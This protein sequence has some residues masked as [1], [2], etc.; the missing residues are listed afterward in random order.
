MSLDPGL[1]P[2]SDSVNE[3]IPEQA[4]L[5]VRGEPQDT[6]LIIDV[7]HISYAELGA[8]VDG[9]AEELGAT[10]R[11]VFLEV[12]NDV[13]SVVTYLACLQA[14]HPVLLAAPGDAAKHPDL[15][16]RYRP[17]VVQAK[18]GAW[19]ELFPGSR[20][21][22]HPDL[23]VL[24]ST[25]GSTG[26]PRLVRLSQ[27]NLTENAASIAEYL[28][29]RPTDRG[30]TTLPLNYCYGLSVLNSHLS[31]GAAVVLSE[32]SVADECFWTLVEETGVMG[33]AGVPYTFELLEASGFADR[34]IVS[35]RYL[36]Q[37]GGR[38]EPNR[39]RAYA[40]LGQRGGWDLYVMYGATEATA[41]MAYL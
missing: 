14:G 15:F 5:L 35:L 13:E 2:S 24:L 40:E 28:Q 37:A 11:L 7:Q 16:E 34:E 17:D 27:R 41:R 39:V 31:V 36:T 33:F 25:S 32:L 12:S 38:M 4:H 19:R 30:I 9:R 18:G 3:A 21:D 10:R 29:L 23:A 1:G 22:L 26:S 8:R 6:A 20:H